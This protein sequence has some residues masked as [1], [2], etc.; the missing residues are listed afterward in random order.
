MDY[1]FY[2]TILGHY[3]EQSDRILEPEWFAPEVL[4]S[5][6]STNPAASDSYSFGMMLYEMITRQY[7]FENLSPMM[8]GLKVDRLI[9]RFNTL[10]INRSC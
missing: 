5:A 7:P 3:G 6:Y 1:G 10:T 4:R 9:C 2:N 8:I